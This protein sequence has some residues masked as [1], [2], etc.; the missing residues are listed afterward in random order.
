MQKYPIKCNH[1]LKRILSRFKRCLAES[2]LGYQKKKIVKN[3]M[4]MRVAKA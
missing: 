4:R 1:I 2:I 3:P